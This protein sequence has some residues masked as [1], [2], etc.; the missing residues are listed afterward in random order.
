MRFIRFF[1]SERTGLWGWVKLLFGVCT[2]FA[3]ITLFFVI[4]GFLLLIGLGVAFLVSLWGMLRLGKKE[5]L[6]EK[7]HCETHSQDQDIKAKI[8]SAEY[9]S[10]DDKNSP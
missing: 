3:V 9:T 8:I 5:S 7:E 1:P 6:A 4:G 10:H 2:L